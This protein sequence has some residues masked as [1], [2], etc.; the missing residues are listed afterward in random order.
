MQDASRPSAPESYGS[1]R[2]YQ[3]DR[4]IWVTLLMDINESNV[5]A[6]KAGS[7][8]CYRNHAQTDIGR[9]YRQQ[10]ERGEPLKQSAIKLYQVLTTTHLIDLFVLD[11]LSTLEPN[12]VSDRF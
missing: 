7:S 10:K 9:P 12:L 3:Y 11:S 8:S 5:Y 2:A 1:R 6:A 4:G